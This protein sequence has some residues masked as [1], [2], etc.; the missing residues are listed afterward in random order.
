M[1][2][3]GSGWHRGARQTV[4]DALTFKVGALRRHI[5]AAERV[6]AAGGLG[7]ASTGTLTWTWPG[8][9]T[10]T[11]SFTVRVESAPGTVVR[12]VVV[13]LDYTADGVP[14]TVRVALDTTTM[15]RGGTRH[16]MRCPA[17]D[18]RCATLHLPG[19]AR[20]FACRTCHAL[21]YTSCQESH[22]FDSMFRRLGAQLGTDPATVKRLLASRGY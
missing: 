6:Q 3:Y 11:I 16:W 10:S 2:G 19:G 21:T 8:G 18:G 14:V 7:V 5:E 22:K 9:Q 13:V 4:D 17:C 15:H 20:R 12:A 1:G